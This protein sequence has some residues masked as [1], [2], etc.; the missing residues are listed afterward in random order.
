MVDV[1]TGK[2][3]I[4]ARAMGYASAADASSGKTYLPFGAE[5]I[6]KAYF[7]TVSPVAAGGFFW[8]FFDAMRHYG[9]LGQQ[10][11][12]W[13]TAIEISADGDYSVDRSSPAFYLPGQEFGTGNH[14]AFT[15]LDPCKTDGAT[16]TSGV[17]CCGGFCIFEETGGEF[18]EKVGKCSS[19]VD[20]CAKVEETCK[21]NAD[22]CAASGDEPPLSCIAGYCT[23][24][25]VL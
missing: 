18:V 23:V 14:R 12:L 22:C 20:T 19:K 9:N 13:G 5:D 11:Q 8:V 15:A 4:L 16:C 25:V 24:I 6:K 3:T 10:R 2:N 21:T 1:S 17:D 7:P